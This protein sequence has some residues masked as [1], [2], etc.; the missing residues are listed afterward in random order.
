MMNDSYDHDRTVTAFFDTRAAADKAMADVVAAGVPSHM[1]SIVEGHGTATGATTTGTI[2]MTGTA[3]TAGHE[4]GFWGSVK[5]LFAPEEDKHAY[6][7]GL[8]RG[9]YLLTAHT[10]EAHYDRVLDILDHEGAVDMNERETQW[11][12]EGW[13]G[14]HGAAPALGTSTTAGYGTTGY[15]TAGAITA[16]A[17]TAGLTSTAAAGPV[18]GASTARTGAAALGT[19]EGTI[20]LAEETLRVGKRDVNHGRVRLRSYVVEKPVNESISLRTERVDVARRAVDRPLSAGENLFAERTL[21]AEE[22]QE[23]AVVSKEARVYEEVSLGK[24]AQERTQEITDTVRRTEI[25]VDDARTAGTT[26]TG[27]TATLGTTMGTSIVEHMPVLGSD[28]THVGTVDHMDGT[29]RIKLTKSDS[30]DGQHHYIPLSWVD[31]VD[32]H[33]HLKRSAAQAQ[34]EWT[35]V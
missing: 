23:E 22:H 3:A 13:S 16:G 1:V 19:E 32:T 2:G 29:D 34:S 20:Q 12:S 35:K 10:S 7:E 33:V 17:T 5:N 14:T 27:S 28:G 15:G 26:R 21:S 18:A 30:A 4:E 9:G 31:R 11:R 6:A 24:V 8:S 25:E